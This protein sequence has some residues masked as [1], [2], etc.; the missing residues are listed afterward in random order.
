MI[1]GTSRKTM[2]N[3]NNE[4]EIS[5]FIKIKCLRIIEQS[6]QKM[7]SVLWNAQFKLLELKIN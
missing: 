5:F 1:R 4:L 3:L 7:Q 2:D 6:R